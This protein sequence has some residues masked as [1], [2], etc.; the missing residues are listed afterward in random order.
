MKPFM[1]MNQTFEKVVDSMFLGAQKRLQKTVAAKFHILAN[2][3]EK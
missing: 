2:L 3:F 1:R